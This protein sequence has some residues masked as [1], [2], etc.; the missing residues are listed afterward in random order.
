MKQIEVVEQLTPAFYQTMADKDMLY[1]A[2]LNLLSNS[3]KYT[4]EGGTITV[5]NTVASA[6]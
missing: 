4:P 5:Q 2:V 6:L 3:V 1:Q